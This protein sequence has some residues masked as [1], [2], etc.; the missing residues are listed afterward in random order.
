MLLTQKKGAL[1]W[2]KPVQCVYKQISDEGTKTLKI[3]GIVCSPRK[4]GTLKFLH[5]KH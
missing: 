3:V 1:I 2:R 5:V 4:E